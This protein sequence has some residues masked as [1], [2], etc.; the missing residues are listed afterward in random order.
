MDPLPIPLG[1]QAPQA[2]PTFQN[3][4]DLCAHGKTGGGALS[5]LLHNGCHSMPCRNV[6]VKRLRRAY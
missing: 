3:P 1:A 5:V 6:P 2:L 4:T